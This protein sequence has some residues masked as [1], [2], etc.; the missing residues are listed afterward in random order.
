MQY[1]AGSFRGSMERVSS[2]NRRFL[3]VLMFAFVVAAGASIVLYKLVIGRMSANA[4]AATSSILVATKNLVLG[5]VIGDGDLRVAAWP[6]AAPE[7]AVVKLDDALG[8][9]VAAPIYA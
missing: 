9:G 2:M 7:G 8:R 4:P 1:S 6:G 3:S 5:T